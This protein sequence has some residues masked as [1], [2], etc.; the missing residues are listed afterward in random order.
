MG[1]RFLRYFSC[2]PNR[3][4]LGKARSKG[5]CLHIHIYPYTWNTLL[6]WA[7]MTTC[8]KRPTS[9]R[10][11]LLPR[12]ELVIIYSWTVRVGIVWMIIVVFIDVN[13]FFSAFSFKLPTS[14]CHHEQWWRTEGPL[15]SI[16]AF[17][18]RLAENTPDL[19]PWSRNY[20]AFSFECVRN[21]RF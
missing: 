5:C 13:R 21:E 3:A 8:M 7:N 19:R 2:T 10:C 15:R 14:S 11:N 6:M 9:G 4:V 17:S 16:F 18:S 20:D 12:R 1:L